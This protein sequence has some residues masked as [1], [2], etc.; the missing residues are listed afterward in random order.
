[1]P[2]IPNIKGVDGINVMT[3]ADILTGRKSVGAN[4]AV[5]GG[6]EVGCETASFIVSTNRKATIFEMTDQLCAKTEGSVKLFLFEYL[7]NRDVAI[8]TDTKVL[9]LKGNAV[10]FEKNGVTEELEGFT[11]IIIAV[12]GQSYN[13]LEEALKDKVPVTVIGD[14]KAVR[15]GINAVHEGFEAAYNL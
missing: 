14:A 8:Y 2:V 11:D 9:E 7:K 5:I 6:G 4:A 13:P 15:Q 1:M 3:S 12:G 10:L